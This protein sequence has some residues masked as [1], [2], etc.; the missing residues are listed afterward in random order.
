MM[1]C[2]DG[3]LFPSAFLSKHT[4]YLCV[5]LVFVMFIIFL[6]RM[7]WIFVSIKS[8]R[9]IPWLVWIGVPAGK[10][11]FEIGNKSVFD[12]EFVF[13]DKSMFDGEFVFDDKSKNTF[14]I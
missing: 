5:V 7:V 12:D 1:V 11:T 8:I 10:H 9:I 13:D 4:K 3:M 14:K 2:W 6:S